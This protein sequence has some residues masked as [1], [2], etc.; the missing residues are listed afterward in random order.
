M[1]QWNAAG[2]VTV[3]VIW[4]VFL[5]G[6]TTTKSTNATPVATPASQTVDL[7][8]LVTPSPAPET[9]APAQ[10]TPTTAPATAAPA[11]NETGYDGQRTADNNTQS[12]SSVGNDTTSGLFINIRAGGSVEG[13]KVFIARDGTNVSPIVYSF[14]PDRTVVEGENKGYIQVKI[15]PDGRSG[16]VNLMPGAYTAY[17]PD[18]NGGEPEQQSFTIRKDEITPIWF[19][20]FS[21][22]SGGCGC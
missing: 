22:N 8:P 20:G 19:Q 18:W 9:P 13:L 11:A 3:L 14:L 17:L 6:C 15:P 21:A 4:M 12:A 2:I 5:G 1:K 16:L 7:T 10:A